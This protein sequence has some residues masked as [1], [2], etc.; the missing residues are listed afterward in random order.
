M[1]T[2][3]S[4]CDYTGNWVKNYKKAGYQVIQYDTALSPDHDVRLLEFDPKLKVHGIVAQFPCTH[5]AGSG[6]RWWKAKGTAALLEA[7][8]IADACSRAVL[9]YRKTLNWWVFENPVGRLKRFYGPP[10]MTF[11]P[12]EYGGYVNGDAYTKRTCLWGEFNIPVKKP[13]PP[14]E[15]SKMHLLPPSEDRAMLRSVTPL[16]FARAFFEAN[17]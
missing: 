12:C 8:S 13:V 5:F 17:P 1:K 6:A 14:V 2:I 15:G 3:L 16:G 7:L 11:Q 9:I 10:L 4:L